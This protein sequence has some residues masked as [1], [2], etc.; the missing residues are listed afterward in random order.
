MLG[1]DVDNHTGAVE[2]YQSLGMAAMIEGLRYEL[3]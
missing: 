2:L 1:V 3:V